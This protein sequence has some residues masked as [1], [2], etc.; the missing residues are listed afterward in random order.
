MALSR[1][2]VSTTFCCSNQP[3]VC[4]AWRSVKVSVTNRAVDYRRCLIRICSL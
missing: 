1:L 3:H 4:Q 2:K